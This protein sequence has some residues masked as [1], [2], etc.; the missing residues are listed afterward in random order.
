MLSHGFSQIA[1]NYF[2]FT[3]EV[4]S[5]GTKRHLF[6]LPKETLCLVAGVAGEVRLIGGVLLILLVSHR[7]LRLTGTQNNA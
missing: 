1:K 2:Q 4:L 6:E 5:L 3:R 7:R